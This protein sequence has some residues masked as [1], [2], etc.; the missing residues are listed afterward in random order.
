MVAETATYR[1]HG[2]PCYPPPGLVNF[3]EGVMPRCALTFLD[4]MVNNYIA[5]NEAMQAH[6]ACMLEAMD[7]PIVLRY[8]WVCPVF[9]RLHDSVLGTRVP[10][11]RFMVY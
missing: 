3:L 11:P 9:V 10:K 1:I 6:E 5:R 2:A 8:C 7:L 4:W